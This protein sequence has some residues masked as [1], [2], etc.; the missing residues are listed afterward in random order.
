[1]RKSSI[2][3]VSSPALQEPSYTQEQLNSKEEERGEEKQDDLKGLKGVLTFR[4][5]LE[6]ESEGSTAQEELW[7]WGSAAAGR[8]QALRRGKE[9]APSFCPGAQDKGQPAPE[10][11]M[12]QEGSE[13]SRT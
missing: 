5:E 2:T 12:G 6:Q 7:L 10:A 4:L 3:A 1:M 13:N 9:T 8:G 11:V